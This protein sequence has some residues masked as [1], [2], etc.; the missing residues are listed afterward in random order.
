MNEKDTEIIEEKTEE[1]DTQPQTEIRHVKLWKL[2]LLMILLFV[3]TFFTAGVFWALASW[4][5]ISMDELIWH[6]GTS[7]KG[8]NMSMVW[9]F[10]LITV[11]S[12]VLVTGISC[13]LLLWYRKRGKQ[14]TERIIYR[15]I[16]IITLGIFLGGLASAWFGFGIGTYLKDQFNPSA[17]VDD[18]YV[19]PG[20]VN[21]TF[22]EK[23][24]NLIFIYLESME[25]TFMDK[26]NGG[27]FPENVIPEL[28]ELAQENDSFSGGG[29]TLNGGIALPGAVWTMGAI[30]GTTAGLPLKTPLGQNRDWSL[31]GIS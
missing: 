13:A 30:F 25:V 27:A 4:S 23:K 20:N 31:W 21:I 19:D 24:R 16:Q 18:N 28:T 29:K 11:G 5:S 10:I 1:K 15:V 26:E 12:A 9:E 7:L 6:L 14:R 22:P 3:I 17:Y 8:S 2:L